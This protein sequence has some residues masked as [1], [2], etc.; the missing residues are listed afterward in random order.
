MEC[1]SIKN[2]IPQIDFDSLFADFLLFIRKVLERTGKI[3]YNLN[4]LETDDKS[5]A[6]WKIS[7]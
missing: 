6:Y 5:V 3:W 7:N 1:I 4:K 2:W